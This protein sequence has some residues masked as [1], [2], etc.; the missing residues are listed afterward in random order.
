[1]RK[2]TLRSIKFLVKAIF[3]IFNSNKYSRKIIDFLYDYN[4]N[5]T[6]TINHNNIIMNH[7]FKHLV[8][9]LVV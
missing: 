7:L 1:M 9:K 6:T 5:H 2:Y 4:L 3:K 8:D